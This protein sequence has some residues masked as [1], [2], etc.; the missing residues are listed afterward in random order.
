MVTKLESLC[1]TELTFTAIDQ[2]SDRQKLVFLPGTFV[3]TSQIDD[4]GAQFVPD[5]PGKRDFSVA[6]PKRSKV[7]AAQTA[8]DHL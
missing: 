1:M 2:R 4:F 3:A 7:G 6:G 8:G 5:D